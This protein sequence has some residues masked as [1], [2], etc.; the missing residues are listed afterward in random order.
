M[1]NRNFDGRIEHLHTIR[2][3]RLNKWHLLGIA[4]DYGEPW[5]VPFYSALLGRSSDVLMAQAEQKD[6]ELNEPFFEPKSVC[7]KSGAGNGVY[8]KKRIR[9]DLPDFLSCQFSDHH[10]IA[11][12]FMDESQLLS[13]V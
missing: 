3:Q 8:A 6:C 9:L 2:W 10:D 1:F 13:T 7:P 12:G 5:S 11:D 4:S